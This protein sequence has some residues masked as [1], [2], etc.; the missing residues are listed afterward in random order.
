[1]VYHL[2]LG[3]QF[4]GIKLCHDSFEDLIGDGWQHAIVVVQAQRFED[5]W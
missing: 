4:S 5:A 1:M 2:T 3:N